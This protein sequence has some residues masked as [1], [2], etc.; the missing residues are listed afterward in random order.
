MMTARQRAHAVQAL[1]SGTLIVGLEDFIQLR[2]ER[3]KP[4]LLGIEEAPLVLNWF[5]PGLGAIRRRARGEPH[6]I[7]FAGDH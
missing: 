6:A 2:E 7:A 1:T 5:P 4:A 3:G